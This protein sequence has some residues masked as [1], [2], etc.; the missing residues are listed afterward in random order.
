MAA[1]RDQVIGVGDLIMSRSNDA[2]ISVRPGAHH[3]GGR[4]DQIRNGNRWRVAGVDP[5]THRVAAERITDRA[6]VVFEGEYL[7]EHV[8]LG[9]AA[10][11]HSA[12]VSPPTA[13]MRSSVRA[14]PARCCMWR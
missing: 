8:T 6:R 11:V 9:Y 1:A 12:Q 13:A 4:V 3:R 5:A 14:P 10:T 7:R 2:T